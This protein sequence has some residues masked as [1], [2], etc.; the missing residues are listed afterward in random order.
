[1]PPI[2]CLSNG[3]DNEPALAALLGADK[4]IAGTVTS[5]V[6]R[7]ALGDIVL[8]KLRGVGVADGH[9]LSLVP[10]GSP[11]WRFLECASLST[12]RRYEMV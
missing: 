11:E 5:S 12:P 7:R 9:P 8:E 6:A 3:V 2:L 1:M 10:L 4:V